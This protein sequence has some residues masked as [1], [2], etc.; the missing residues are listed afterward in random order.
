MSGEQPSESP[1][2]RRIRGRGDS[3]NGELDPANY[4]HRV[5]LLYSAALLPPS[6]YRSILAPATKGE[7]WEWSERGAGRGF[8]DSQ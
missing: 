8:E 5:L 1:R 4:P 3:R 2:G 6:R 7:S